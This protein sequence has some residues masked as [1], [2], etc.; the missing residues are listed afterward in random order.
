MSDMSTEI[1]CEHCHD[2]EY[3]ASGS[4]E[5]P[6]PEDRRH[7]FHDA[8]ASCT[9]PAKELPLCSFC[10]HLR[11][12][13]ILFCTEN[14]VSW[15][16]VDYGSL[17]EIR[18]RR[19]SGC[20][21]CGLIESSIV[22]NLAIHRLDESQM[23]SLT[24]DLDLFKTDDEE[25]DPAKI[26]INCYDESWNQVSMSWALYA[27]LREG[28]HAE[29]IPRPMLDNRLGE[30]TPR[31]QWKRIKNWIHQCQDMHKD[32]APPGQSQLPPGFRLIDVSNRQL[33]QPKHHCSFVALSY[34]WGRSPDPSKVLATMS[35]IRELETEGAL[36]PSTLPATIEDAMQVCQHLGERYLWA[37][38]LCIVQDDPVNKKQQIDS[39]V[40]IYSEANFVLAIVGID[41]VD[42][43]IPGVASPRGY[44]TKE[45]A[46]DGLQVFTVLPSF[47]E[48]VLQSAWASRGWTYQEAVLAKRK[49]YLTPYQAIYECQVGHIYEDNLLN[50]DAWTN[51]DVPCGGGYQA[52]MPHLARLSTDPRTLLDIYRAHIRNY[53]AR[54]LTYQGDIYNA[55]TGILAALY[56]SSTACYFGLPLAD[57][58]EA[59]L[60][61]SKAADGSPC[62]YRLSTDTL[63]PSWSWASVTGSIEAILRADFCGSVATWAQVVDSDRGLV[64][65]KVED[66]ESAGKLWDQFRELEGAPWSGDWFRR[67]PQISMAIAVAEGCLQIQNPLQNDFWQ[68]RSC[69]DTGKD[70][71]KRWPNFAALQQEITDAPLQVPAAVEI[72]AGMLAAHV[73]VS[74]LKVVLHEPHYGGFA[75]A[76]PRASSWYEIRNDA[77]QR[78]GMLAP[79]LGVLQ[80]KD[81]NDDVRMELIGMSVSVMSDLGFSPDLLCLIPEL[82]HEL[83]EIR[84]SEAYK[85]ARELRHLELTYS[86][87]DGEILWPPPVMNVMMI[88]RCGAVCCRVSV[89]WVLLRRWAQVKRKWETIV[90]E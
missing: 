50:E 40:D 18:S 83:V 4:D 57:L 39:M 7:L 81:A 2:L 38:R 47:G 56:G 67:A 37:D 58:G 76:C 15:C 61:Y 13:H 79:P 46:F 54:S 70:I 31:V 35:N 65:K 11:L 59:L 63:M 77:D 51:L 80:S 66:S 29:P 48:T 16:T 89:G 78:I 12:R 21:F 24:F 88:E 45:L 44:T 86:D 71:L 26:G 19:D 73:Q 84:T 14:D 8:C 25:P 17:A 6:S 74:S 60:W 1:V 20:G 49:L 22:T 32:C 42:D 27:Y 62:N 87:V 33:V 68:K 28:Q 82:Q 30:V 72:K 41:S 75:H 69:R 10:Q 43:P 52:R 36:H 3:T 90:L 34:V 85:K 5:P 23:P 64:L 53:S 9:S 55:F